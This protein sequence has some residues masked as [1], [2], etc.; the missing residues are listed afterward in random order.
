MLVELVVLAKVELS[1]ELK[2]VKVELGNVLEVELGDND[3]VLKITLVV[4]VLEL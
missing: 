1:V 3:I 4:L 2:L